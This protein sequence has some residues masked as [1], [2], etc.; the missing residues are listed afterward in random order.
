MIPDL[1]RIIKETIL[2]DQARQYVKTIHES[3]LRHLGVTEELL[4]EKYKEIKNPIIWLREGTR[5]V[6]SFPIRVLEWFGIFSEGIAYRLYSNLV[7]TKI[8]GV[9]AFIGLFSGILTIVVGWEEFSNIS[10]EYYDLIK[11]QISILFEK[12]T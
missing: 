1:D 8:S 10:S 7:V 2:Q 11:T 3:L 4:E 12:N 9:I 6:L 5:F